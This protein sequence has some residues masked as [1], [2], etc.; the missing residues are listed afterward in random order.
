MPYY[1]TE[2][3]LIA[4][5]QAPQ[6]IVPTPL[7]QIQPNRS[8]NDVVPRLRTVFSGDDLAWEDNSGAYIGASGGGGGT[9][10]L[11]WWTYYEDCLEFLQQK[12]YIFNE[13]DLINE[14]DDPTYFDT[15]HI[16]VFQT[17]ADAAW[18]RESTQ[19]PINGTSTEY[20]TSG[21]ANT[22][23]GDWTQSPTINATLSYSLTDAGLLTLTAT[24]DYYSPYSVSTTFDFSQFIAYG[25][26]L[27]LGTKEDFLLYA[28]FSPINSGPP[29]TVDYS[30]VS[31]SQAY[32]GSQNY[33]STMNQGWE[34]SVIVRI[35]LQLPDYIIKRS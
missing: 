1:R 26:T 33:N 17:E 7:A 8:R 24:S 29:P 15:P 10:M 27:G 30:P 3:L 25:Q 31:Y 34:T 4:A 21:Y 32:S 5:R 22:Y 9:Y 23:I 12:G 13:D 35:V 28:G 6:I 16:F 11:D 18:P 2:D 20:D 19:Y 14:V